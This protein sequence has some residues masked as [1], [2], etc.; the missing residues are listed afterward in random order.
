MNILDRNLNVYGTHANERNMI[1][2]MKTSLKHAAEDLPKQ[3]A[4]TVLKQT[5]YD[6]V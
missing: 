3:M 4:G 6:T 2:I 5:F 1:N